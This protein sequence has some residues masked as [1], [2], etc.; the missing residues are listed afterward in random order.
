VTPSSTARP[1][2]LNLSSPIVGISLTST[3]AGYYLIGADGGVFTFGDAGFAGNL[4]T[5]FSGPSPDGPAVGL[6][7]T[8]PVPAT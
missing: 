4:L 7:P 1:G 5:K 6:P 8:R 3:G 2:G